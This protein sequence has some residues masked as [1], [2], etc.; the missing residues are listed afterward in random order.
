MYADDLMLLS[1]SVSG[2][3]QLLDVCALTANDLCLQFNDKKSHCII[4]GPKHK[5]QPSSVLLSG[6]LLQW[7]DSVKYLGIT[8]MS[9]KVFSVDLNQVRHKFFGCTNSILVHSSGVSELIKLH[10]MESN[11]YPVLSYGLECFNL[12]SSTVNHLN[13][14]WN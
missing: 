5:C 12:S 6:K 3:Q 11:C 1:A 13:A 7:V 9:T 14:Y 4:V 2:L 10:L 8:F